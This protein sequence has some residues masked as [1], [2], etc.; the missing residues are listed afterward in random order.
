MKRSGMA[1]RRDE[2]LRDAVLRGPERFAEGIDAGVPKVSS[3]V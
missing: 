2:A 1:G 3:R